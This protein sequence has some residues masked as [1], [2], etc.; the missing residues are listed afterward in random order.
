MRY[1]SLPTLSS[2]TSIPSSRGTKIRANLTAS[3]EPLNIFTL[4]TINLRLNNCPDTPLIASHSPS[5]VHG[6]E[7][8]III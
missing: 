2:A 6:V 1:A 4:D 8:S 7:F 3:E 5:V